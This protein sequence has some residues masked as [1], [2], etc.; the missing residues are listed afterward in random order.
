MRRARGASLFAARIQLPQGPL[1]HPA[2]SRQADLDARSRPTYSP[3]T[4]AEAHCFAEDAVTWE[5]VVSAAPVWVAY[6]WW[7]R[8]RRR[9]QIE[10]DLD[11]V[12][13][14]A[15]ETPKHLDPS[16]ARVASEARM[17]ST[18]LENPVRRTVP[19]LLHESPWRR[20]ER[21]DEYDLALGD[22]RRALWEWVENVRHLPAD[23]RQYLIDMGLSLQPFVAFLFMTA[24]RTGDVWEQV[25][26]PRAPRLDDIHRELITAI[27]EL[28]RFARVLCTAPANPYRGAS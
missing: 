18:L 22:A 25:L 21:C 13:R 2:E 12:T 28:D 11:A 15:V 19:P 7:S 20:R 6:R 17:L 23:E 1:V 8:R 9:N 26:Y 10:R 16:L 14:T 27:R 24:D 5:G 3:S 4:L